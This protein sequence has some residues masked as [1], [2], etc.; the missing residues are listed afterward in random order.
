LLTAHDIV[1]LT[2]SFVASFI[3]L[4]VFGTIVYVLFPTIA[5]TTNTVTSQADGTNQFLYVSYLISTVLLGTI[6]AYVQ[7]HK[8]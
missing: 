3:V 8:F 5:H 7:F 6:D 2:I 4:D 1:T